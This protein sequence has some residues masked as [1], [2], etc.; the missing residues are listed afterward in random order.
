MKKAVLSI[1]CIVILGMLPTVKADA[2]AYNPY[3][4][5]Y[6]GYGYMPVANGYYIGQIAWGYPH[7]QGYAYYYDMMIGWVAYQ[8]GFD[9]GTFHGQGE[10]LCAYG[11]IRGVWNHN[12]FVQQVNVSQQQ[13]QQSYNNIIQQSQSYAPQNSNT[14]SLPPGTEI[15]EIDSSSELGSKLLGK[16]RK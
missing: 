1:L 7:G 15:K 11:Y 14:I 13:I 3:Y 16:M 5:M 9:R 4:A 6:C 2:Q 12:N 10:A 8:G